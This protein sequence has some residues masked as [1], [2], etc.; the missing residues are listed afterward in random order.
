MN[1]L[2]K[3]ILNYICTLIASIINKGHFF[4]VNRTH[5]S[6]ISKLHLRNEKL[7]EY[8][9]YKEWV[10]SYGFKPVKSDF[11][12]F[13][14]YLKH[15]DCGWKIVPA[16]IVHNFI[17]PILNPIEMRGFYE[18]KNCFEKLIKDCFPRA[19]IRKIQGRLYDSDYEPINIQNDS[20]L[21]RILACSKK[22]IIKPSVESSSGKGIKIFAI[23]DK[24]W[25][26]VSDDEVLSLDLLKKEW[27]TDFIMQAV[28][29][30]SQFMSRF[31]PTSI[32]TLRMV[33][34][35]SVVDNSISLLWTIMRI[36]GLGSYVDNAHSG[37]VYVGVDATGKLNNYVCNQYGEVFYEHNGLNFKDTEFIVPDFE[38]IIDFVKEAA[39]KVIHHRLIAFDIAIDENNDYKIVEFNIRG[40][41]GWLGEFSG[42]LKFGDK[43][44]EIMEYCNTRRT[45]AKKVFYQIG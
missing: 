16:Y 9:K 22:V 24:R 32:N 29:T 12:L 6:L 33:T 27:N 17:N 19:I 40:F 23:K 3:K 2:V 36:G 39:N 10:R 18:D 13:Y 11:I 15:I 42:F 41:S 1:K 35:R 31:N 5:K 43:A 44:E 25:T 28:L 38:K 4:I 45:L 20:D 14:P 34:Y 30:Q 37:G 26:S 7:P 21:Y 8:F